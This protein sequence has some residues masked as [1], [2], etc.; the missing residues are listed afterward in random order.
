MRAIVE[1][2]QKEI[3]TYMKVNVVTVCH[4]EK[5]MQE[6]CIEDIRKIAK[7]FTS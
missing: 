2:T 5:G 1:M 7:F 4:W 6:P 3:A